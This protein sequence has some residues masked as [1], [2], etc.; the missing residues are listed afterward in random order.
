MIID[1][2]FQCTHYQEMTIMHLA[3]SRSFTTGWN[4][5]NARPGIANTTRF[6][7]QRPVTMTKIRNGA[8]AR[9]K[10]MSQIAWIVTA[11]AE[12][13]HETESVWLTL[14][15]CAESARDLVVCVPT[16]QTGED[17]H[18]SFHFSTKTDLCMTVCNSIR[19]P[20]VRRQLI[21]TRT[22]DGATAFQSVSLNCSFV[23]IANS[24]VQVI[25]EQKF[26]CK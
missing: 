11:A 21:I 14:L 15:I 5:Q 18:A 22:R 10:M 6:G 16:A 1:A 24:N 13:G 17:V 20:G 2:H 8:I 9:Q 25:T 12:I 26:F 7:V 23:F 4:S 3:S 19:R